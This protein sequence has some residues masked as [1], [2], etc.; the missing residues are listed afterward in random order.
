M[1]WPA[2]LRD[3]AGLCRTTVTDRSG[4]YNGCEKKPTRRRRY[5]WRTSFTGACEGTRRVSGAVG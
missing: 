4:L 1:G 3:V 5:H 2:R